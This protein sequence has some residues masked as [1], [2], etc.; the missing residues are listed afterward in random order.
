MVRYFSLY[1]GS[2]KFEGASTLRRVYLGTK[3]FSEVLNLLG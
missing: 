2:I 1:L 3:K